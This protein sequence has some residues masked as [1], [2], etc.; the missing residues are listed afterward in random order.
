MSRTPYLIALSL[1]SV[2]FL[3]APTSGQSVSPGTGH[4]VVVKLVMKSGSVPYAFE[5]ANVAVQH[6]D[7]LRFMEDAGAIHNVHFKT[8]PNGA[9][10]G[11]AASGPYL[12]SKGQTYDLV[13][14]ARFTD[15]RYEYVCDP[16]EM[17]GMHGV[18]TVESGP[19]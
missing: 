10:L 15:G 14:D 7:T 9:R 16:H 2:C 6:G 5:P 3:S 12:T 4:L 11:A 8:H 18:L 13:I 1:A 19:K 17:I